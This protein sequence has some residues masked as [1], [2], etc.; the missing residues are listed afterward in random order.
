M[1]RII[2]L[3]ILL[4]PSICQA[5]LFYRSVR[6]TTVKPGGRCWFHFNRGLGDNWTTQWPTGPAGWTI[7]SPAKTHDGS[8]WGIQ[9]AWCVSVPTTAIPGTYELQHNV[10]GEPPLTVTVVAQ[11]PAR[12]V[13]KVCCGSRQEVQAALNDGYDVEIPAGVYVWDSW[14]DVPDGAKIFGHGVKLV[15]HWTGD[16]GTFKRMFHPLGSMTLQGLTLSH[17]DSIPNGGFENICYIHCYRSDLPPLF[18]PPGH[19]TVQDC[20]VERG[21]LIS[22][23]S[24][25]GAVIERCRFTRSSLGHLPDNCFITDCTWEGRAYTGQ[26]AFINNSANDSLC[27][28]LRFVNTTRGIIFQNHYASG[29]MI[30]DV[31]MTGIRGGETIGSNECVLFETPFGADAIPTAAE[32]IR[33]NTFIDFRITDCSGIGVSLYGAKMVRNVFRNFDIHT[34]S[35]GIAVYGLHNA[36]QGRNEFHNCEVDGGLWLVGGYGTQHFS[37]LILRKT[38]TGRGNEGWWNYQLRQDNWPVFSDPDGIPADQEF[39]TSSIITAD[40]VIPLTTRTPFTAKSVD[41]TP[42]TLMSI[43]MQPN[44]AR[45]FEATI[46]ARSG[47]DSSIF[48]RRCRVTCNAAGHVETS[49]P[50][51]EYTVG[52]T[53]WS[54]SVAGVN[55]HFQV[56]G[57]G[58][59]EPLT[60]R[61]IDIH[62]V[63]L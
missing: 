29:N 50:E 54:V 17:D 41:A 21:S 49:T 4:L 57:T 53:G 36:L 48:K 40:S 6:A 45:Y 44:E 47:T 52:P 28:S 5:E 46:S 24:Q 43:P 55:D 18:S 25:K 13:R 39:S 32:T 59:A 22:G 31:D 27:T 35:H 1:L 15:R 62:W 16:G 23:W 38:P 8:A 11:P 61:I 14:I 26:H 37:N 20:V 10:T 19:L 12:P 56:Y 30:L 3:A 58:P 60:W 33:D 51:T 34:D 9:W 42:I 63:A 7:L 2:L